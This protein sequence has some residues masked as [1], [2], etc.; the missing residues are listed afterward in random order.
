[1]PARILVVDDEPAIRKFF[2]MALERRGY[3]VREAGDGREAMDLLE[4]DT[5]DLMITDLVMPE[6]EGIETIQVV[7]R[8]FPSMKII[9]ISG[10]HEGVYL[11]MTRPLGADAALAK[12][13]SPDS[14]V[15]EVGRILEGDNESSPN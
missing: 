7:R 5:F 1:M 15:R 3:E 9:A 2:R 13:I 12:P 10:A 11:R 6:Q 8:R 4:G 14:L